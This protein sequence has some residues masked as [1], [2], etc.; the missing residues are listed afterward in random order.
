MDETEDPIEVRQSATSCS[1]P[2]TATEFLQKLRKDF[3]PPIDDTTFYAI[4][5]DH[6][7]ASQEALRACLCNLEFI[8]A[9]AIEA[10]TTVFD[11]SGTGGFSGKDTE[12]SAESHSSQNGATSELQEI[13]SIT[14]GLSDLAWDD[15]S[16]EGQSLDDADEEAKARW[17]NAMFP[18][19]NQDNISYRL[20][21]CKGNLTRT[22]DEL[23]N[24]SFIDKDESEG[25]PAIPRGIDGFVQANDHGGGRKGKGKRRMRLDDSS[26]SSSAT[27]LDAGTSKELKNVWASMADDVEFIIARTILPAHSIKSVYNAQ[28]RS[29]SS[30]ISAL[31]SEE[32]AKLICLDGLDSLKQVQL[33]ELRNNFPTVAASQL[34]GLLVVSDNTIAAARELAAEMVSSP[35][36]SSPGKLEIVKRYAPIDLSSDGEPDTFRSSV[37][38]TPVNHLKAKDQATAKAAA[39]STAFAQAGKDYRRG[40]SDHLMGASAAYHAAVGHENAKAAK[41]LSAHAAESLVR[42]QSTSTML[43]LHG[44]SVADAVRIAKEQVA[45]WWHSLGDT[46][47]AGGAGGPA[48][49]GYRV[50]TGVGRHSRDGAPKIGP[51]VSRMLVREGWKVSVGQGEILV[52]SSARRS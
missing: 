27:S 15:P 36:R 35:R 5:N 25:P 48:R 45:S 47:Y 23:L 33:A 21:K 4:C 40:K 37:S 10:D 43:D 19:I 16:V 42:S 46:K 22:I 41:E 14:T 28:D 38:W 51:A 3:C 24:L 6:D 44:V 49:E 20:R 12:T 26:R 8:K 34:Y 52:T 2:N 29:L 1:H 32:G 30:T 13:D 9:A 50:V 31:A 39:A 18:D 7:L 11:A 17:L